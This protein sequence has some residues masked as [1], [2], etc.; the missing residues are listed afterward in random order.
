MIQIT[1]LTILLGLTGFYFLQSK[2]IFFP[3]SLSKEHKFNFPIKFEE[4]WWE[5]EK[6][7]NVHG[8]H[9]FP[10]E[11]S[12]K[13]ILYFHGNA[14]SMDSWGYVGVE[15]AQLGY[16]VIVVDY[17][18]YGKSDGSVDPNTII[19]DSLKV[20]DSVAK[21]FGANNV[22]V[23]G[24]SIGTP[25]AT[26]IASHRECY[27]VILETP[28]DKLASLLKVHYP[29]FPAFFLRYRF[30]NIDKIKMI[31]API[32]IIHGT[33]DEVI[34]YEIGHSFVDILREKDQFISVERGMH[35]NLSNFESYWKGIRAF[36]R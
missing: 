8:L 2:L 19:D 14:G 3:N 11:D 24:R 12:H 29:F 16:Q 5:V 18:G 17:R 15:L 30:N 13:V 22:V 36:L 6:K 28:F 20:F 1:S 27:K 7:I 32:L 31:R 25:I 23:Y 26:F 10:K 21:E 9:F 4:K 33:Q 34:P 35:N